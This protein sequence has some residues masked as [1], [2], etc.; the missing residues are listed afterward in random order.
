MEY[1]THIEQLRARAKRVMNL[2]PA[3]MARETGDN[4]SIR[5]SKVIDLIYGRIDLLNRAWRRDLAQDPSIPLRYY[6]WGNEPSDSVSTWKNIG[7]DVVAMGLLKRD[8]L[9]KNAIM[10]CPYP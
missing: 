7:G 8:E 1:L 6:R 10:D 5:R 9:P 2:T 3:Q 4:W